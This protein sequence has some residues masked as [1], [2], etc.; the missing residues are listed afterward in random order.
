MYNTTEYISYLNQAMSP[1]TNLLGIL[2]S[3]AAFFTVILTFGKLVEMG[4]TMHINA[5]GALDENNE[6]IIE[7]TDLE[8]ISAEE[9]L[10]MQ[11][12][13]FMQVETTPIFEI[14]DNVVYLA[15][16]PETP[17]D[18]TVMEQ[19]ISLKQNIEMAIWS[20]AR[21]LTKF[22]KFV[23]DLADAPARIATL[24]ARVIELEDQQFDYD[25]FED[26]STEPMLYM[27]RS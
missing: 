18:T 8:S 24:E 17:E 13:E 7:C 12:L 15:E 6:E 5:L 21:R 20:V 1:D 3:L 19:N 23:K 16:T 10:D 26:E 27:S 4:K 9:Y 2:L 11:V 22:T 25:V 14:V